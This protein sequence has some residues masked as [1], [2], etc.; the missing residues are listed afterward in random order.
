MPE[1]TK[2]GPLQTKLQANL[3]AGLK[4]LPTGRL[5]QE[6][7][8]LA[9]AVAERALANVTGKID[10]LAGRLT[11]YVEEGGTGLFEAMTGTSGKGLMGALAGQSG[12]S[13]LPGSLTG[14]SEG[15]GSHPLRAALG[16]YAK[17]KIKGIFSRIGGGKGG[18]GGKGKKLKLTNIVEAV[19]VGAPIRVVYDQWT[20]FEDFPS[21]MKKVET[22]NQKADEKLDWKAQVWWSH[23]TWESTIVEQVPDS[24]I[25][26]RSQGAKGYADGAVTFHE[27]TPDMTRVLLVLEYHPQGL[28]ERTG[29]LWRAQGR[30]ARLELK[31]FRRHVMSQVLLNPDEVEGWR[32]E[33]RDSQVVKDH[34]TAIKEERERLE[35]EG[36]AAQ[37]GEYYEEEPEEPEGEFEEEE[38]EEPEG[39]LEEEEPEE[40]REE[41]AVPAQASRPQPRPARPE[42]TA[43]PVRAR[44]AGPAE[45]PARR[46][47]QERPAREAREREDEEQQERRIRRPRT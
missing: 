32:G 21:F 18:K 12:V 43:R 42:R 38:P 44:S 8:N 41:R 22:V 30:R 20:R 29:N 15:G 10:K 1:R 37:A 4:E 36:E 7:Q 46:R 14:E 24:R 45:R 34:E 39:E 5:G 28:F 11:S 6:F 13:G 2:E 31:H 26:W 9:S 25:I 17:E 23:R 16:A 27:L 47:L 35:A 33:I 19:D 40:E 3:Q